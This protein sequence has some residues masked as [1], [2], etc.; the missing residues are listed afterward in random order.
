MQILGTHKALLQMARTPCLHGSG[1]SRQNVKGTGTLT[2]PDRV[3]EADYWIPKKTDVKT[4]A[5]FGT[6]NKIRVK[7][8]GID[9]VM[10]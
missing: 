9:G 2:S 1:R 7:C 4:S 8:G 3:R 6:Q 10:S 5:F